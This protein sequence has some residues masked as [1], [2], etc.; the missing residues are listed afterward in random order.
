MTNYALGDFDA[1]YQY[2]TRGV[3]LWRL[4]GAQSTIEEVDVPGIARL[5]HVALLRYH[6]NDITSSQAIIE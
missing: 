1:S 4:G 2:A 6:Q 3:E 5:C